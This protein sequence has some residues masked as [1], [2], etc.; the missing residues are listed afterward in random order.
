M[1]QATATDSIYIVTLDHACGEALKSAIVLRGF[2]EIL[3][4]TPDQVQEQLKTS[5]TPALLIIDTG[6]HPQKTVELLLKLP[7]TIASLVL[8]ETFDES[9]FVSCYDLGARDFIVKPVADVYLMAKILKI[10][11]E[12]RMGQIIE[13]KDQILIETGILSGTSGVFTTHYFLKLL[14]DHAQHVEERPVSQRN[15]LSL[16]IVQVDSFATPLPPSSETTVLRQIAMQIRACAR[17]LDS[18]G[19][20][21]INKFAV[22]LPNTGKKGAEALSR[23]LIKRIGS[24]LFAEELSQE[25][26]LELRIG[27]AEYDGSTHY[28]AFLHQA[29]ENLKRYEQ[30]YEM[31]GSNR[32]I[33][34]I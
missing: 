11:N 21:F 20:Y 34:P 24:N 26:P 5:D 29:L 13:Q 27:I 10:L 30:K 18:V 28:E 16:L 31:M 9:F 8:S 32:I 7:K 33:H 14:K 23:R 17:G 19:E 4:L 15:N 25:C 12:T 22:L 3:T 1:K 2:D 6:E